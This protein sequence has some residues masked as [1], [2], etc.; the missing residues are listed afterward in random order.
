MDE[1]AGKEFKSDAETTGKNFGLD[2]EVKSSNDT[3]SQQQQPIPGIQGPGGAG[4]YGNANGPGS[5]VNN[6]LINN[7][8]LANNGGVIDNGSSQQIDNN[9][10]QNNV[11]PEVPDSSPPSLN[12]DSDNASAADSM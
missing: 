6:G 4:G 5:F 11:Q 9:V 8:Q 3:A 10:Q 1:V 12:I 7:G 2:T